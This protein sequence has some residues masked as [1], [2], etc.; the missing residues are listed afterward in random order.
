[1]VST[2]DSS[3]DPFAAYSTNSGKN[4]DDDALEGLIELLLGEEKEKAANAAPPSPTTISSV[5]SDATT[6]P[7]P[8]ASNGTAPPKSA[9]P[10]FPHSPRQSQPEGSPPKTFTNTS[11][12][13]GFGTSYADQ[14]LLNSELQRILNQLEAK[15]TQLERQVYE[16]TELINPL[17][18]LIRELLSLKSTESSEALLQRF[19]PMVDEAIRLRAEQDQDKM[20][21]AISSILPA[22][23]SHEIQRAPASMAKALAPELAIAIQEQIKLDPTAMAGALGPQMGEAIKQQIVVE[24]DAMVDALYPVIGN[25]IS[26]Y[27]VEMVKTMNEKMEASLSPAGIWRKIRA[28][29]QGISEAELILR[30]SLGFKIR[31]I[32]L[33]HKASGLVIR[34]RLPVSDFQVESSM[35]AGMLTAIR[36]FVNDCIGLPGE[37]SELHEIEYDASK[38][39]LE[40]AGYCYLAVVVKGEPGKDFIEKI[41]D[42]LGQIVLKAEKTLAQYDGEPE[43]VPRTVD[44][45]IDEL[46][47]AEPKPQ[48][49]R[50]RAGLLILLGLI[51]VPLLFL[52]YRS[53]V[54]QRAIAK[55]AEALD[56]APELSIYRV[57]PKVHWGTLTLS[58]RLPN[59]RL[60]RQAAQVVQKVTPGWSLKNKIVAVKVPTEPT[61][62]AGELERLIWVYSQKPG[63]TLKFQHEFGSDRV[64][65][66]GTAATQ[67]EIEQLSQSL[68]QI[69]GIASVINTVQTRPILET[70]LYFEANSTQL[71]GT[72]NMTKLKFIQQFLD[73]HPGVHLKI[74]GHSD[75]TGAGP[76]N[77]VISLERAKSVQQLLVARG[78]APGRLLSVAS[79]NP[80]PDLTPKQPLWLSRSV[81]FEVFVPSQSS[82]K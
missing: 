60:R 72:E 15:I 71:Q 7:P 52:M 44:L 62:T 77:Q 34:E 47:Q 6:S 41:R 26:K 74:I 80:P 70:R 40:V 36:N 68:N 29:L 73:Q 32:L 51:L 3:S 53:Y 54:A 28:K 46:L 30:E 42:T 75:Q 23:I 12:S 64:S 33:I 35:M 24:R 58:G 9:T 39:I 19:A 14:N 66:S 5:S 65:V 81:R 13:N 55:A 59:D 37:N 21:E 20:G 56:A 50:S 16:P 1:M 8:T 48:P 38:I 4:G 31:A 45:L 25:T 17:L 61:V 76:R 69:P 49:S 2:P 67:K 27:M 78:V 63:T 18:P 22:A 79:S 11:L 43:T 57:D 82:S 10:P